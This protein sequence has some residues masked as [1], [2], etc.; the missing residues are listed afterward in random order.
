MKR[1]FVTTEFEMSH[2]RTPRGY[3][4]WGFAPYEYV[5]HQHEI[6]W[7]QIVWSKGTYTDAKRD[8]AKR[9]PDIPEWIV[10]P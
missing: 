3:G 5:N 1:H 7:D 9:H 10:L 4:S 2:G 8:V 6:P